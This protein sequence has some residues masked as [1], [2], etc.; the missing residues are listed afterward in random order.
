MPARSP[1]RTKTPTTKR[2]RSQDTC[3]TTLH[4]PIPFNR[5]RGTRTPGVDALREQTSLLRVLCDRR[6][7]DVALARH[8]GA[9]GGRFRAGR[10]G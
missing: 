10:A 4:M 3:A 2:S 8:P 6:G 5:H 1:P 9:A 7:A